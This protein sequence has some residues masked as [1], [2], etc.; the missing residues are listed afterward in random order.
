MLTSSRGVPPGFAL[1]LVLAALNLRPAITS[2]SPML[3]ELRNDYGLGETGSVLLIALPVAVFGLGAP[4]SPWLIRRVG[5][6][7]AVLVG[8][9]IVTLGLLARSLWSG[10]VFPATVVA[11]VGMTVVAVVLPSLVKA[12]DP[13]RAGFWTA[14]YSLAIAGGAA[15]APTVSGLLSA[16]GVGAPL[17]L[18]VWAVLALISAGAWAWPRWVRRESM[19]VRELHGASPWRMLRSREAPVIA[20]YFGLQAF[21]FFGIVAYL[22]QYARESGTNPGQA[23]LLMTFF[24]MIAMV[25]SWVTPHVATRLADV[26]RLALGLAGSS[27]VGLLVLVIGGPILLGLVLLA[28]GQGCI[29]PLV[30]TLFVIRAPDP[31]TAG[32]ISMVAQGLGFLGAACAL[33]AL[34]FVYAQSSSWTILWFVMLVAGVAQ[35][36]VG[37]SAASPKTLPRLSG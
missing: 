33:V 6:G 37:W 24:S 10:L 25:C 17:T 19:T 26:R 35:A 28:V 4:M 11:A 27:I 31:P 30:L 20:T 14:V 7:Q 18:G 2:L 16:R 32:A 5:H 15:A 21:L 29:L 8:L 23:G 22:A 12:V 34:A 9:L 36:V 13:A 3:P 1:L